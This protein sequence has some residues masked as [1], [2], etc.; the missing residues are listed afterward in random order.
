MAPGA[1]TSSFA[2]IVRRCERLTWFRCSGCCS[3]TVG[4]CSPP[5]PPA[6]WLTG[7]ARPSPRPQGA[8]A[9]QQGSVPEGIPQSPSPREALPGEAQDVPTGHGAPYP[10]WGPLALNPFEALITSQR[11][12]IRCPLV[13]ETAFFHRWGNRGPQR[14]QE[15]STIGSG[16]ASQDF[17]DF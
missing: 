10:P 17:T 13:S 15:Q 1:P 11:S 14:G 12:R 4:L 16:R 5:S 3:G 7:G 6:H 9:R 8:V 2:G